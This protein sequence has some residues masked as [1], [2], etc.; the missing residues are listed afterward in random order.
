MANVLTAVIPKLLAQGLVALRENAVTAQ[1]VNRKYEPMAGQRGSSIDIPI[2]SAIAAQAVTPAATPP[3]TADHTPTSVSIPLDQWYEAPFY[4]TDKEQLEV[5]A[6]HTSMMATE[7][8]KSL[9]NVVDVSI[10]GEYKSIYGYHGTAGTTPFGTPGIKDAIGVRKVLQKQLAPLDP[11]YCML[12]PDAE[13]GIM[14]LDQFQST[15]FNASGSDVREGKLT[16]KFG[17]NWLANQNMLTHT[18]GTITTGLIAK[19]ST[20]QAVGTKAIVCTTAASTGA[21]ALKEGDIITFAGHDQTYVVT[22]DATQAS[23]ATDVTVNISPG[24]TTALAGSE[25]VTV[26]ASHVVNLGFHRDCIAFGSRPL[27]DAGGP[28]SRSIGDPISGLA[29]RLEVTREHKRWRFAYDILWGVK[30]VRPELGMRLAG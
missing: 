23:A 6:G 3:S 27:V 24:L 2:P 1:I 10:L 5:M 25:A 16:R 21:C 20:A 15:D 12:D 29:L 28:M 9:V 22:A 17:L 11:R 26:K 8:I 7:A 30:C 13:A 14:A 4:L 19:A 18:A